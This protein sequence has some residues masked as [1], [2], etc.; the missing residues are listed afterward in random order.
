[1]QAQDEG[2]LR[3]LEV[4]LL[5]LVGGVVAKGHPEGVRKQCRESEDEDCP[6]V[7]FQSVGRGDDAKRGEQAVESPVDRRLDVVR[8]LEVDLLVLRQELL[9]R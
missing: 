7:Q 3:A 1:V 8:A 6:V 4:L 5:R 9:I 2:L